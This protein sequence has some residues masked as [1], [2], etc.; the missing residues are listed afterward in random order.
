MGFEWRTVDEGEAVWR[1]NVRPQDAVRDRRRPWLLLPALLALVTLAGYFLWNGAQQRSAAATKEVTADARSSY[2]LG[3]RAAERTDWELF[4][5]VLSGRDPRWTDVQTAL[6]EEGLLFEEALRPFHLQPLPGDA[7]AITAT[8]SPDL[9]EVILFAERAFRA[10]GQEETAR[11]RQPLIFRRGAQGWLLSPP[12]RAFWGE[13]RRQGGRRL[14]LIYPERDEALALRI[15]SDLDE[16]LAGVCTRLQELSCPSSFNLTVRLQSDPASLLSLSDSV[17]ALRSGRWLDLPSPSLIGQPANEAGYQALRRGYATAAVTAAIAALIDYD[18][19]E[20]VLFMQAT[21][22]WQLSELG[23]RPWPLTLKRYVMVAD[24]LDRST[25]L[26]QLWYRARLAGAAEAERWQAHTMV[27]LLLAGDD[28][29]SS[30]AALQRGIVQAGDVLQ[31]LRLT[32]HFR[33]LDTLYAA[34]RPLLFERIHALQEAPLPPSE[35]LLLVC[36]AGEVFEAQRYDP[37]A[38]EWSPISLGGDNF[39]MFVPLPGDASVVLSGWHGGDAAVPTVLWQA[40]ETIPLRHPIPGRYFIPAVPMAAARMMDPQGRY[41][42]AWVAEPGNF[43]SELVLLDLDG[44]R[45]G[46]CEWL[47]APGVPLWSAD[48]AR[49]LAARSGNIWLGMRGE[50]LRMIAQGHS[51]FWLDATAYGYLSGGYL[52]LAHVDGDHPYLTLDLAAF[53]AEA[54]IGGSAVVN[55]VLADPGGSGALVLFGDGA[56]NRENV[57]LLLQREGEQAEWIERPPKPADVAVLLRTTDTVF[58]PLLSA[59]S[60][61]GRWLSVQVAGEGRTRGDFLVYD[62]LRR[63]VVAS[64]RKSR[65]T[66]SGYFPAQNYD[67]TAGGDW[68]ARWADGHIDLIAPEYGPYRRFVTLPPSLAGSRNCPSLAWIADTKEDG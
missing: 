7:E 11:L 65:L 67:W 29:A 60:P 51:P 36:R 59:F 31:W 66:F 56:G 68:L 61:D 10:V 30:A 5:S 6:L 54:D 44:C 16:A 24:F 42:P 17:L 8:V 12:D 53:L 38:G 25:Q 4:R 35:D 37:A 19:C 18:C 48:G 45:D 21:V 33:D 47:P 32:T 64:P 43:T 26:R 62:R 58:G 57:V 3:R 20:H 14:T 13:W 9:R 39:Y 40:G 34:W 27:E 23:I 28:G 41:L 46:R 1:E 15:L 49:L 63:Q 2:E 52:I 50:R 22:D 55:Y